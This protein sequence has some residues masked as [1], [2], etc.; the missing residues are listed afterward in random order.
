L[1]YLN[2]DT[3]PFPASSKEGEWKGKGY[4]IEENTGR[5]IFN[6]QYQDLTV[7]DKV[8]PDE[9]NTIITHEITI[10]KGTA[11]EGLYYKLGEGNSIAQLPDGT[12]AV[13]DKAYYIKVAAGSKPVI[14]DVNGRKELVAPFGQTLRYSII[15]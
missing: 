8:F 6:Y 4:L 9:N 1:V 13:D 10:K 2:S 3:D 15:W 5:P 14:R 11:K 7:E 12:F